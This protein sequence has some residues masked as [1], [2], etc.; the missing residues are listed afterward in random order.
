MALDLAVLKKHP[1]AT[2]GVIIVGALGVFYV[3]S[4]NGSAAATSGVSSNGS[5][6]AADTALGQAQAAA[7][8]QTNAQN[9]QLQ[10]ASLNAS[11]TNLQT[12]AAESVAN[13]QTIASL[14][15]AL[16]GNKTSIAVT[17]SNNDA[18]TLQQSNAEISQQN[19]YQLQEEALTHQYDVAAA[20]AANNNATSLAAVVDQLNANGQIAS[21]VISSASDLA[22]IQQQNFETNVTAILPNVG[23]QYNSALD[24]N[25]A[26]AAY[27]T[28][29]SGGNPYVAAAGTS[30]STSATA[31]GNAAGVA[32]VGT[33]VG[34][35]SSITKSIASG[36]IGA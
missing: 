25:N 18:A 7:A 31:S 26:N 35:I 28:I 21:Q 34:G 22:K 23:K 1:Y 9:A 30:S 2:G 29:L 20:E 8:V 3:L 12:S 27:M 32:T 10:V 11:S 17:Q 14:V 36:F 33:I 6:L 16:S 4:R 13:N 24:A 15:A 19:I 5:I